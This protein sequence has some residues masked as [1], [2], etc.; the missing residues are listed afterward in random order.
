SFRRVNWIETDF[1]RNLSAVFAPAKEFPASAHGPCPCIAKVTAPI[2]RAM[3]AESLWYKHLDGMA[4]KLLASITE[5]DLCLR[6]NQG[7]AAFR[8]NHDHGIGCC[9]NHQT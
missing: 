9:F 1:D 7:D 3:R 5:D 8:V 4:N 6:V 2:G